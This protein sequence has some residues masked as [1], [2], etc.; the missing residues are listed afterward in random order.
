MLRRKAG[1]TS[2]IKH[3]MR[4]AFVLSREKKERTH[5]FDTHKMP[6]KVPVFWLLVFILPCCLCMNLLNDGGYSLNVALSDNIDGDIDPSKRN[7]FVT[8]V[9]VRWYNT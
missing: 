6:A 7:E 5:S 8:A 9:Q 2:L 3:R 4:F 1:E